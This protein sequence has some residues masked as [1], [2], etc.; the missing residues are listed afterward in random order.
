MSRLREEKTV[1]SRLREEKTMMSACAKW[2]HL[3]P[4]GQG[5]RF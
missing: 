4:E 5:D 2:G 3:P 1:M